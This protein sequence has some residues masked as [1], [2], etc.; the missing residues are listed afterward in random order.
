MRNREDFGHS[1]SPEFDAPL[2]CLSVLCHSI[3][4]LLFLLLFHSFSTEVVVL[5]FEMFSFFIPS[6]SPLLNCWPTLYCA[7]ITWHLPSVANLPANDG[8]TTDVDRSEESLGLRELE[9]KWV[10]LDAIL[11]SFTFALMFLS[12]WRWFCLLHAGDNRPDPSPPGHI[13]NVNGCCPLL[14]IDIH[15]LQQQHQLAPP[16]SSSTLYPPINSSSKWTKTLRSCLVDVTALSDYSCLRQTVQ[17][18]NFKCKHSQA[19][20]QNTAALAAPSPL[21][22][23]QQQLLAV[24]ALLFLPPHW[25]LNLITPNFICSSL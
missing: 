10:Y 24:A 20:V 19:H 25:S 17:D 11:F 16:P 4:C 22:V 9:R 6:S 8:D 7:I 12:W 18:L 13:A 21:F 15:Y 2:V 1:P 3:V 5:F 23:R 14:T